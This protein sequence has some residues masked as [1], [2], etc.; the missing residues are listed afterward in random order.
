M[1]HGCAYLGPAPEVGGRPVSTFL[2][3]RHPSHAR[4]CSPSERLWSRVGCHCHTSLRQ[5]RRPEGTRSWHLLLRECRREWVRSCRVLRGVRRG[6]V[7]GRT[8]PTYLVEQL[9]QL[10]LYLLPLEHVVFRLL[11]DGRD[12]VELPSH[13]VGLLWCRSRSLPSADLRPQGPCRSPIPH[14][15][16]SPRQVPVSHEEGGLWNPKT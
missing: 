5:C 11:A 7:Q 6:C 16:E 15:P 9:W 10:D 1:V 8:V 3:Q 13:R 12:Q 4:L 14:F 2:C